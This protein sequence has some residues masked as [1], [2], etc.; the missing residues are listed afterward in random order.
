MSTS[1]LFIKRHK[2]TLLSLSFILLYSITIAYAT[3]PLTPYNSGETL[4]PSCLPG[5]ANCFV[6]VGNSNGF[7]QDGN[8]FGSLATLGTNDSQDLVLETNGVER[9]RVTSTGDISIANTLTLSSLST[10]GI[11]KNNASGLVSSGLIANADVATTAAIAY[12]KLNLANSIVTGD[13]V[14]GSILFSDLASNSCTTG[15]VPSYNG[16]TWVC[17]S[18]LT[19]TLA[20]NTVLIGN[21]SNT[22]TSVTLSG[23]VTS[24][25]AGVLT[26]GTSAVT[27]TKIADLN[28]TTIKL[29]DTAVTLAKLAAD[30]VNSSKIVDGSVLTVDLADL[31]VTTAKINDLAITTSKLADDAVTTI[32]ILN[33]AVTSG[34]ILDDAVITSKILD[35]NVTT[36]KINTAAITV[37]KLATDSVET[38]KIK[39]LNVTTS[40]LA[41]LSV[42][43]AKLADDSVTTAKILDGTILNAD[44][45][46]G[47]LDLTTKVTGILP[48]AN[49]GT[50]SSTKNFVDLTTTQSIAGLKTFSAL[51]T[52]QNG[53][54]LST[55]PTTSAGSYDILTRNSTTGAVEKILSTSLPLGTGTTNYLAR[56]TGTN[57]LGIGSIRDDGTNVGIGTAPNG[58]YKLDVLGDLRSQGNLYLGNTGAYIL[59]DTN[60]L[61]LYDKNNAIIMQAFPSGVNNGETYIQS[62]ES[63]LTKISL[64]ANNLKF[65][66]SDGNVGNT[67]QDSIIFTRGF[68]GSVGATDKNILLISSSNYGTLSNATKLTGLK[69]DLNPTDWS[70][71]TA[72]ETTVGN[73]ILGSVSGNVGIGTSTPTKKLEVAGEALIDSWSTS[74][75]TANSL[76]FG[77][78]IG[79]NVYFANNVSG[80][81][82]KVGTGVDGTSRLILQSDNTLIAPGVNSI[83]FGSGFL[84]NPSVLF[85]VASTSQGSVPA[86]LMT[87]LQRGAIVSP[88]N[89]LQVYNTTTNKQ[90]YFD[91]TTWQEVGN[92]GWGLAGNTLSGTEKLGSLNNQ[93][94]SFYT[95]NIKTM[96]LETSGTLTL[97]GGNF[98]IG[99]F[100]G[101]RQIRTYGNL[102]LTNQDGSVPFASFSG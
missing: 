88:V 37:S 43:A 71:L 15:Q 35:L 95:N 3:P 63:N 42:T 51:V 101:D 62:S 91:G 46:N 52:L 18:S 82:L 55:T 92:A 2:K 50:G 13:I 66:V 27:T 8:S 9:V 4:D 94:L 49:G 84:T 73:V 56:W 6:S 86:P 34:K 98:N 14:D 89:G 45:A 30:S 53:L 83:I 78:S 96:V 20:N 97:D 36:A 41:D 79:T 24:T 75:E 17:A 80:V 26:I 11:L 39:D 72:L 93:P 31:N 64:T 28:V 23:D 70:N 1:F 33:N 59:S 68:F 29:A 38:I 61:R 67:N 85:R 58:S 77:K 60:N 12:S 47:T 25:N 40:K 16:A 21:A 7:V 22:A 69:I 57:T 5:S 102:A 32:K 87:T 81:G 44:I 65:S 10:P 76:N 19:N 74:I 90:N 99:D 54:T 48:I 100:G